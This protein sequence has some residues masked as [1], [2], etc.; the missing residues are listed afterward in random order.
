MNHET[1]YK[2]KGTSSR[3]FTSIQMFHTQRPAAAGLFWKTAS[4]SLNGSDPVPE[5]GR[6]LTEPKHRE[7]ETNELVREGLRHH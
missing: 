6:P 3:S 2:Q 1:T 7:C 4:E 5:T